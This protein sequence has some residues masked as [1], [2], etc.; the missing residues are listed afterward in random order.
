MSETL[1]TFLRIILKNYLQLILNSVSATSVNKNYSQERGEMILQTQARI[2]CDLLATESGEF[3]H[4]DAVKDALTL[5]RATAS[6][7]PENAMVSND[8]T[9]RPQQKK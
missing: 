1:L 6:T 4:L 5:A 2:L 3:S 9:T 8:R 7:P